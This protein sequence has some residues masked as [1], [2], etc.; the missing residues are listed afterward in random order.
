MDSHATTLDRLEDHLL[1]ERGRLLAFVRARIDDPALAEDVLQD[2]LLR[3]V[4]AAPDLRDDDR[5]AA[6]L[7][8]VVRNAI[9]DTYRRRAAAARAGEAY[10]ADAAATTDAMTPEDEARACACLL[11]L[12]PT[13][14]PEYAAVVEADLDGTPAEALADRLGITRTNL[15]VRR[16][17]AHRQLRQRLEQTCRACAVHGCVDC[18]CGASSS[19]H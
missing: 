5:M 7:Y 17:R 12:V 1:R 3:A 4:A 8:Q 14:K 6:W 18:S 13:L 2:S 19:I 11:A 15:K 10:A 9:T 16:H